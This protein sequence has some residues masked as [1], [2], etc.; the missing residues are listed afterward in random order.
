MIFLIEI[1]DSED[2]DST[3]EL[4]DLV[5]LFKE[6][7]DSFEGEYID[8]DYTAMAQHE[9]KE[10]HTYSERD[11]HT[12]SGRDIHSVSLCS[13]PENPI[14]P[15]SAFSSE[16]SSITF[17]K[18]FLEPIVN[19]TPRATETTAAKDIKDANRNFIAK[20]STEDIKDVTSSEKLDS[21]IPAP[22]QPE[23]L[24]IVQ[25]DPR[26]KRDSLRCTQITS[27]LQSRRMTTHSERH[28]C[29]SSNADQEQTS[30]IHSRPPAFTPAI[31][32]EHPIDSFN[33]HSM[34]VKFKQK[35]RKKYAEK[36]RETD[37]EHPVNRS[38][39][40][41]SP[42]TT[43]ARSEDNKNQ[44]DTQGHEET[45]ILMR[46]T[47]VYHPSAAAIDVNYQ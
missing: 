10:I 22:E 3:V 34:R 2:E 18:P 14:K 12:D 41:H 16:M 29:E 43:T 37:R 35:R 23:S 5:D 31:T 8:E 44:R 4:C 28:I 42:L 27:D 6:N 32:R 17:E 40:I 21:D 1:D 47:A 39:V 38:I 46:T 24:H 33:R 36:D 15:D 26:R 7:L 30:T 25:S 45:D 11:I 20:R 19:S 13:T 9:E